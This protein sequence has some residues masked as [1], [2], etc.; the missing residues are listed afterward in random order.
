MRNVLF[1]FYKNILISRVRRTSHF[2]HAYRHAHTHTHTYTHTHAHTHIH[3]YTH[4]HIR[5][6]TQRRP[7]YL[8]SHLRLAALHFAP[9][10]PAEFPSLTA[11]LHRGLAVLVCCLSE[12][13]SCLQN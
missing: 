3:I 6:H 13:M 2:T 4:T 5:T 12:N 9:L 10:T 7:F 1:S 8:A 11:V